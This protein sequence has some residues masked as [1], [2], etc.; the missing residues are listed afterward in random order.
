MNAE[1]RTVFDKHMAVIVIGVEGVPSLEFAGA[2]S[3]SSDLKTN[4]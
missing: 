1:F 4:F 2:V 3:M